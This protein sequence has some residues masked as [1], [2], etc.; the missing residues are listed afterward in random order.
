MSG[1]GVVDTVVI[2]PV[3][4]LMAIDVELEMWP[5]LFEKRKVVG[6]PTTD[7]WANASTGASSESA[8]ADRM[9]AAVDI[10]IFN[11]STPEQSDERL[12]LQK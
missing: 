1:I 3:A 10:F 4:V 12:L 9:A 11:Q 2:S 7:G 5:P 8:A 6:A